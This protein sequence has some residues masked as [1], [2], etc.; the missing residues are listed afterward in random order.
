MRKY[1]PQDTHQIAQNKTNE[2]IH[3]MQCTNMHI[4]GN[5][6]A[7]TGT[8]SGALQCVGGGFFGKDV[9]INGSLTV[10]G[11]T[12]T[13]VTNET[14]IEDK[15]LYLAMPS[16]GV[17]DD[18]HA[19]GAG[20]IIKGTDDKRIIWDKKGNAFCISHGLNIPKNSN[21]MVGNKELIGRFSILDTIRYSKLSQ[22]GNM[23]AGSIE[24][25]FGD[26]NNSG[27]GSVITS[28]CLINGSLLSKTANI[29][30]IDAN[31][32]VGSPTGYI[33]GVLNGTF[34]GDMTGDVH[35]RL[36]GDV[37]SR[38]YSEFS[39]VVKFKTNFIEGLRHE[40][41]QNSGKY[42]HAGI[43]IHIENRDNPHGVTAQQVGMDTAQWNANRLMGIRIADIKP[44]ESS[45]LT[46]KDNVWKSGQFDHGLL[47]GAGS[48][49]HGEID[50]HIDCM[51]NPHCVTADQV[52]R[53]VAQWN[54][55]KLNGITVNGR[56]MDGGLLRYNAAA[57]E[58][59][60]G[61][62]DHDKLAG[63][64]VYTHAQIDAHIGATDNPHKVTHHHV[65]SALAQWNANKLVDIKLP[66]KPSKPS[67]G[68]ILVFNGTEW[69]YSNLHTLI[70][71]Y[72]I[73][74][75]K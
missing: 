10:L 5:K 57:N 30:R 23:T 68:D 35:G 12:A 16:A 58:W 26:I 69:T 31:V 44:V 46:F 22:V 18:I 19:D 8:M 73:G 21:I 62:V 59:Q 56:P 43:D 67:A 36:F 28:N 65:G 70:H 40:A 60:T 42:S 41:L 13:H 15:N 45:V 49:T 37:I 48:H 33:Q 11:E 7:F 54:A 51:N 71:Q 20:L 72:M 24:P 1:S 6:N 39:G 55:N 66:S 29:G 75:S 25:G 14:I 52:G 38:N 61:L 9:I 63:K 50:T 3:D 47:R 34:V 53:N 27:S 32:I 4:T 74:R 64:G 2:V 17:A